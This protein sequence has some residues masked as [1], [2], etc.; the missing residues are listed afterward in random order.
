MNYIDI[1]N[2]KRVIENYQKVDDINPYPF[3]HGLKH[4][5]NVCKLMDRL[6][7]TL[8]IDGSEK[9]ALLIAAAIH[10]VG[11]SDGRN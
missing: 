5:K 11:Q 8:G 10:D 4:V 1:L 7:A 3:N 6:C 9:E 2:D